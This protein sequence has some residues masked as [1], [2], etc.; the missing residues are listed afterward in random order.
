MQA[1][2]RNRRSASIISLVI[3]ALSTQ[4]ASVP[5][6]AAGPAGNQVIQVPLRWCAVQGSTAAANPGALGEPDTDNVLWR[7]HE[8]ATDRILIPG[9]NI[10]FR[11]AV[12]AAVL[13][14]A[15]FPII[16]DPTPPTSGGPGILGDIV[17]P[18]VNNAEWTALLNSCTTA[19]TNLAAGLG[20]TILGPIAVNINRFV[21]NAGNPTNL[22]GWGGF[23]SFTWSPASANL[24]SNPAAA[25]SAQGGSIVVV[26]F[27]V[28]SAA[29]TDARLIAHEL[30]HVLRLGHGNG[31]DDDSDGSF[32]DNV[33][34]CDPSETANTPASVMHPTI[35]SG[36]DTVTALQRTTS[37][38]MATVYSG[39][40]IDPPAALVSGELLSDQRADLLEDVTSETVDI[41]WVSMA[42]NTS[43]E[44]VLFSHTLR[45]RVS[46]KGTS[47]YVAFLDLDADPSTGGP[48]AWLGFATEF[49][50]AE[51]V[52][53]VVVDPR[54][55]TTATVWSW[56]GTTFVDMTDRGVRARVDSPRGGEVPQSAYDVVILEMPLGLVGPV[57]PRVRFQAI[58]Q[59]LTLGKELDVVPGDAEEWPSDR[60]VDVF[61]GQ[62]LFPVCSATPDQIDPGDTVTIEASGFG[63]PDEMV[64]IVL[65]DDLIGDAQLDGNGDLN[66]DIV[67]PADSE[68][69]PRLITV[70]VEKTALTADCVLQVGEDKEPQTGQ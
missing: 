12:T 10:T 17:D 58:A 19:W 53:R 62:P 48:P 40:Q 37:R 57:Q 60:A 28:T 9:A 55:V 65:G 59:Q 8:R 14:N 32:D 44:L 49:E 25:T 67:I 5:A 54:R 47:Q 50:G 18:T 24:C 68:T 6:Y 2:S 11:S 42:A 21:D 27:S 26:D 31:V 7:R 34:T 66:V 61:F 35:T 1:V 63:R 33:F 52:T 36:N 69:G 30:G 70:G 13:Q 22:W 38:A 56:D 41:N 46:D 39:A 20:A 16:D 43:A 29:A 23:T 3:L 15:N 51:L 45:G 4:G 64:H